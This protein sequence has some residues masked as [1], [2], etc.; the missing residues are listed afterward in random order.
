MPLDRTSGTA[1][2]DSSKSCNPCG[3]SSKPEAWSRI[4]AVDMSECRASEFHTLQGHYRRINARTKAHDVSL[5]WLEMVV[6]C[7]DV[8]QG[9]S[10]A[11]YR[12][13]TCHTPEDAPLR[14]PQD[15][16]RP[17]PNPPCVHYSRLQWRNVSG[18]SHIAPNTASDE[19]VAAARVRWCCYLF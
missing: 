10:A 5:T 3:S 18:W 7:T 16:D 9:Q 14:T 12:M 19:A 2:Y 1:G 6:T 13:T 11:E 8:A 4:T 15:W 17:C